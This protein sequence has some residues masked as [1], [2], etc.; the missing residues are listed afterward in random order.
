MSDSIRVEGAERLHVV[1]KQLK[2][3]GDKETTKAMTKGIREAL[4]PF[5]AE[6][7]QSALATLPRRGGL[8][9]MVA[10]TKITNRTSTTRSGASVRVRGVNAS[11]RGQ[12]ALM[13][14][15]K[16]RH[17]LYGNRSVWVTQSV[18]P[19]WWSTPANAQLPKIRSEVMHAIE[20]AAKRIG[21]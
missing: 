8:A 13:D 9:R 21:A 1:A 17:P 7:K 19:G 14:K 6:L 11:A 3:M 20:Q 5:K 15:G 12:L 18:H 10:N 4:K 16:V 2:E